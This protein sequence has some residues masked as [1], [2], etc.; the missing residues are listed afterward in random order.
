MQLHHYQT[1]HVS[2][3]TPQLFHGCMCPCRALPSQALSLHM[4]LQVLKMV[5]D[6]A[7]RVSASLLL[8]IYFNPITARGVSRLCAQA[9]EAGVSGIHI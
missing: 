7:P 9:R 2:V 8:F 1:A 4:S 3:T 6:V 5:A